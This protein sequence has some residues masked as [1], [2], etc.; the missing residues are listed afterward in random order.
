M[1]TKEY[2]EISKKYPRPDHTYKGWKED[3]EAIKSFNRELVNK[4]SWLLPRNRWTDN[5]PEDYDYTYTELDS[6]PEGWRIA[7]GDQMIEEIHQQLVKFNYVAKFRITQIKEKWGGL[8][9]YCDATPIGKLSS[10]YTPIIRK[11]EEPLDPTWDTSKY[12]LESDHAEH[13]IS[14]FDKDKVGMTIEE[15]KEYN[16]EAIYYYKLYE[17]LE[18]CTIWDIINHYED[19][20]FD[21]CINCGEKAEWESRGWISPYCTACATEIMMNECEHYNLDYKKEK[22]RDHFTKMEERDAEKM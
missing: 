11:G 18:K 9:F 2:L 16:K 7:F 15:I 10:E 12:Y 6:M 8:R 5:T 3:L 13:Y 14:I 19:I 21:I 1:T 22:L 4:Y 20:S 17:I